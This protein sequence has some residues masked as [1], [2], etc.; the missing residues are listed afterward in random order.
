MAYFNHRELLDFHGKATKSGNFS[1]NL[2]ENRVMEIFF[3]VLSLVIMATH[4]STPC[5]AK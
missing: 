2:L 3:V 5:L 4:F 1:C